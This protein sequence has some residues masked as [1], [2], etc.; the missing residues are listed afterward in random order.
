MTVRCGMRSLAASTAGTGATV[1]AVDEELFDGAFALGCAF[2]SKYM[3]DTSL[4]G[5]APYI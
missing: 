4:C 5:V 1:T 3:W 2:T